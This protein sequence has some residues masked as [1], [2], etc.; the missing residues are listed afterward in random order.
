MSS[1]AKVYENGKFEVITKNTQNNSQLMKDK[2][3]TL[4]I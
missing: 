4:N 3:G 1:K 2:I